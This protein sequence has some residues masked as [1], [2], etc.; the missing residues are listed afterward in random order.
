MIL[1]VIEGEE[2]KG[3][4]NLRGKRKSTALPLPSVDI[5]NLVEANWGTK[6]SVDNIRVIV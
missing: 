1:Y 3:K 6:H 5:F 4:Q 2:F